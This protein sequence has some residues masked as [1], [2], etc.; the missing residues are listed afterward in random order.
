MVLRLE[1]GSDRPGVRDVITQA[2]GP[3]SAVVADLVDS[4]RRSDAWEGQSFVAED[5]GELVG[6]VLFTRSLLDAPRRLVDVQVLSPLAVVP[7]RQRLGIGSRL[8]RHGLD[9]LVARGDPLV[10][11]EGAPG[12]YGRFGFERASERGFRSPS[13]RV[14]DA[15][16]QVLCLPAHEAWMT[17]TLVYADPFWRHD[18]VGRRDHPSG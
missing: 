9:A 6:Q 13:L 14:P 5:R 11:L 8:V 17:G 10:F 2:F 12:Y 4:L 18:C 3:H 1:R 15:A 7:A 16:F